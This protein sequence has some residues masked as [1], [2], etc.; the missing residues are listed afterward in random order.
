MGFSLTTDRWGLAR[1]ESPGHWYS[2]LPSKSPNRASYKV[3]GYRGPARRCRESSY[4]TQSL[5]VPRS[6]GISSD[7]GCDPTRGC[8]SGSR[9]PACQKRGCNDLRCEPSASTAR[10]YHEPIGRTRQPLYGAR[11]LR[12]VAKNRLTLKWL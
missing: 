8:T 11:Y 12:R 2:T 9:N 7:P 4:R 6:Q 5:F 1:F 10:P 3:G